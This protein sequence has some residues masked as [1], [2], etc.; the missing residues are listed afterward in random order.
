MA[1]KAGFS[2]SQRSIA[3]ISSAKYF[4][5]FTLVSYLYPVAFYDTITGY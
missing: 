3:G 2:I 5:V 4:F 1:I